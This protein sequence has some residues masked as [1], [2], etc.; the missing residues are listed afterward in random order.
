[1]RLHVLKMYF[2]KKN[3]QVPWMC[4]H[5]ISLYILVRIVTT[6]LHG[7][8]NI[9]VPEGLLWWKQAQ[10]WNKLGWLSLSPGAECYRD[11][12]LGPG[13]LG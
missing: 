5:Q 13:I 9:I 10:S 11:C 12:H 7:S 1:M 8:Y 2:E 4:R 6:L 3:T